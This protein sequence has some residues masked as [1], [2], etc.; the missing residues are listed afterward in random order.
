MAAGID[1]FFTGLMLICLD[2]QPNCPDKPY[3]NNAWVVLA[4]KSS[5]PCGW[6]NDTETDLKLL[7]NGQ[8]F[9]EE[10]RDIQW[11]KDHCEFGDETKISCIIKERTVCVNPDKVS[12]PGK[13]D[14]SIRSLLRI[15][16]IDRR[17]K[18]VNLGILNDRQYVP[19]TISFPA[20]VIGAG[21]NWPQNKPIQWYRSDGNAGG[22]L[23][24]ELSDR[25][26]VF[27]GEA[28]ILTISDCAQNLNLIVLE[29]KNPEVGAQ[30]TIGNFAK[31]LRAYP[32]RY[33]DLSYLLWYYPLG[34]WATPHGLCP[35]YNDFE[36]DA[37]LLR[38]V[39]KRGQSCSGGIAADTRFWPPMLIPY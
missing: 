10:F 16:E 29:R 2:G 19:T 9:K 8:E 15:D 28:N 35:E 22:A 33:E 34:S 1:V 3:R 26:K 21:G 5:M 25:V 30:V 32:G 13:I 24:R 6:E 36:R 17:F 39:K 12:A 20:G 4:D 14:P 37:V 7:F 11:A 18:A 23:P 38:C 27:Y 31:T